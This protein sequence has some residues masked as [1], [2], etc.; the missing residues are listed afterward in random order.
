[1]KLKTPNFW[2][3]KIQNKYKSVK[4]IQPLSLK[5]NKLNEGYPKR[6]IS[7]M[8]LIDRN[9]YGDKDKDGLMNW[10]DCKPKNRKKQDVIRIVSSPILTKY[11]YTGI[12]PNFEEEK[13]RHRE[14]AIPQLY[15]EAK[16]WEQKH[17]E[18]KTAVTKRKWNTLERAN[19][20]EQAYTKEELSG[21]KPLKTSDDFIILDKG[22]YEYNPQQ[23]IKTVG[24]KFKEQQRLYEAWNDNEKELSE[25]DTIKIYS[26]K[27]YEK[28][29]ITPNEEWME[30]K[31][32]EYEE[33]M[34]HI[35][36]KEKKFKHREKTRL[37]VL[38]VTV[39]H[40]K[41]HHDFEM[42]RI[43]QDEKNEKFIKGETQEWADKIPTIEGKKTEHG[44]E[45]INI[46]SK[47]R[48]RMT[49]YR[50]SR[51][52]EEEAAVMIITEYPK[53]V[54]DE[55]KKGA[56]L[57]AALQK[58]VEMDKG[59]RVY[60]EKGKEKIYTKEEYS[61]S[62]E[63]PDVLQ[64]IDDKNNNQIPDKLESKEKVQTVDEDILERSA[65]ELVDET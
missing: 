11:G 30:E 5:G 58:A 15:K 57:P 65:Q 4:N 8:R 61:G 41:L 10:F 6:S 13:R 31:K 38:P 53:I 39:R 19:W 37:S 46:G 47:L 50:R 32:K 16:S 7:E 21:K 25:E 62:K 43:K 29:G 34:K 2:G 64:S 1:M 23:R 63:Q 45:L 56:K 51:V 27:E 55:I 48:N 18:S 3:L 33:N 22:T 9:P 12:H 28:H 24:K 17:P 42:E 40:E 20:M 14:K 35:K 59:H 26:S 52:P 60:G 44:K 49:G 54:H 36:R